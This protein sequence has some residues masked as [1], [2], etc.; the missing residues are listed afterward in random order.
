MKSI[1]SG[2]IFLF[3]A[4]LLQA[5]PGDSLV[6][7]P[8]DQG[9]LSSAGVREY[10]LRADE[11]TR[12]FYPGAETP[13][14]GY[15][16]E[17]LGPTL[18][19]LRGEAVSILVENALT[20]AT[21]THWHGAHLPAEADG[22]PHQVIAAGGRWR[23]EFTVDQ[24]EA[25]LWYHPHLI[26]TTAEQVY[27][28][29]AGMIIIEDPAVDYPVPAEYGT[30]DFPVVLQERRF[31]R[32][33]SFRYR[34]GM[35]DI[36]HGYAGNA[37]LTNG[38]I[39][40]VLEAD[41]T[42]LRLRLLNGGNSTVLRLTLDAGISFYQIA[43][44]GGFLEGPVEMEAIVL[45]PGER[46]EVLLDLRS[47]RGR[48]V[49]LE[50]E[51]HLGDRYTAMVIKP[52]ASLR[53]N[54]SLPARLASIPEP[55][56]GSGLSTRPFVM[57]TMG[58]GGRLTINGKTMN[59][60]RIDERVELGTSEVWEVSTDRMMMSTPHSFH[61]HGLQFRILSINGAAP[62]PTLAGYKDTVL[63][64]PGDTVRLLLEFTDYTGLYMYHC[65]MLEHEDAGMMGQ[66]EVRES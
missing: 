50:A 12:Q 37:L 34:P 21:T 42:L 57:S 15:N 60:R 46:A 30:D 45:S 62:P 8:L 13:T 65:H 4:A 40:P 49:R 56:R 23:A 59:L 29:L 53:A 51:T 27:A 63:L 18:K 38:G 61:V 47:Y 20:E 11:G 17:Y 35:P 7:P 22:G 5:A 9:R 52:A 32:D 28:G 54:G 6:I 31:E 26:G 14:L 24:P 36:M 44:D 33:G 1:L 55:G 58:R 66:Y 64:W 19:L 41:T 48:E 3:V 39:E 25:T 10:R 16:G 2:C 43:S